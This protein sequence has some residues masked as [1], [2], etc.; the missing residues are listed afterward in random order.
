ME[1]VIRGA[2]VRLLPLWEA[3]KKS[4]YRAQRAFLLHI[5]ERGGSIAG[6]LCDRRSDDEM[7]Q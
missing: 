7:Q 2:G 6:A 3:L 5:K 4:M 1:A